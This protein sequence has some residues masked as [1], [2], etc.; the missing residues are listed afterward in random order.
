MSIIVTSAEK[1]DECIE[2]IPGSIIVAK[3]TDQTGGAGVFI[4]NKKEIVPQIKEFPYIIQEYIDTSEGI[5]GLIDSTHDLRLV[6]LQGEVVLAFIRTPPPGNILANVSKGGSLI[7]VMKKDIPE[8]ALAIFKSV[9]T[10]LSHF[11][12]RIY[13]ID[14]GRNSDGRWMIIELNSRP[15]LF[16]AKQ[17]KTFE[18]FQEKLADLLLL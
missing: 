7:E 18:Y 14:M 13:S 9:D 16:S 4:G 3:P 17:G 2:K 10:A 8:G 11:K 1:L 12:Q 6:S 15:A 5:P